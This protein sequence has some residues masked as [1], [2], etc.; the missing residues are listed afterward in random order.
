MPQSGDKSPRSK[1]A[2]DN[3]AD[4]EA[5]DSVGES[6]DS[7]CC[8]L[9]SVCLVIT[10]VPIR[11]AY[12]EPNQSGPFTKGIFVTRHLATCTYS[13]MEDAAIP[14]LGYLPQDMEGSDIFSYY[15][16]EDLPYLKQAYDTVM[17]EQGRPFR[18]RSYRFKVQNGHY[19]LLE[20]DWSCF[21]NPWSKKLEF[22]IGKHTVLKG[23]SKPDVFCIN[24]DDMDVIPSTEE[25]LP[26]TKSIQEEI[27][28]MLSETIRRPVATGNLLM[29]QT[30]TKRRQ[31]LAS[32]MGSLLEEMAKAETPQQEVSES[33]SFLGTLGT[34]QGDKR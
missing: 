18:S 33:T 17:L 5:P 29:G 2:S 20:T 9:Q 19:I 13:M 11:S 23:P 15:H 27:R 26:E 8:G 16:P 30:V 31:E 3:G 21:I 32:F 28:I 25:L 4:K 14:F 22:V 24:E 12:S 6:S 7:Q 10:A 34:A 1:R